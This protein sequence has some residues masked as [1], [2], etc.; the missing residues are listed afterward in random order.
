MKKLTALIIATTISIG[1][2]ATEAADEEE[3]GDRQQRG[4]RQERGQKRPGGRNP[5]LA[6]LDANRDGVLSAVEMQ[7]AASALQKLDKNGDGN[8]TPEELV[9][10]RGNREGK[11]QK[12]ERKQGKEGKAGKQAKDKN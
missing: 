4:E 1:A 11:G 9:P 5:I 6:L 2:F 8:L 7:N 10:N 12:G 3:K